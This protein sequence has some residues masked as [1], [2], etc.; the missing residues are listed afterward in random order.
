MARYYDYV[1]LDAGKYVAHKVTVWDDEGRTWFYAVVR[2]GVGR[3]VKD[4]VWAII[5]MLCGDKKYVGRV[6]SIERYRCSKG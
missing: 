2:D 6:G 3:E 4:A 5:D 1:L